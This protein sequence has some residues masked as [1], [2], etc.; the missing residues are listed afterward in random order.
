MQHLVRIF[1]SGM[2]ISFL[3]SL[4]LGS[5]NVAAMQISIADGYF[6]ALSFAAGMLLVEIVYVRISLV[7][8]DK[9]RKHEKILKALEWITLFIVVALAVSSF[10]AASKN[11]AY[12]KNIL[13]SN[14]MPRFV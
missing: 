6:H 11:N 2:I 7:A 4:P 1:F 9:I 3:G 13:L 8:M 14:G 10:I 5:L 12:A